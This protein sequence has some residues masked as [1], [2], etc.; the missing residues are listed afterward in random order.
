MRPFVL[1][2]LLLGTVLAA[3][4]AYARVG[5]VTDTVQHAW[6]DEAKR[7]PFAEPLPH[8]G[9]LNGSF[10]P[11]NDQAAVDPTKASVVDIAVV[12]PVRRNVMARA[13]KDEVAT[14]PEPA[15]WVMLLLG[16]GAMGAA[17]RWKLRRSEERFNAKIRRIE[18]GESA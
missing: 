17:L 7:Q 12:S 11:G 9:A 4:G 1:A 6:T 16:F 15:T 3:P 13:K 2:S 8:D 10:A 18:A 5:V 14:L